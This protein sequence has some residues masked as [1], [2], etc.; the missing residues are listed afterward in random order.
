[1]K[2]IRA[3]FENFRLL[4]DPRIG[5]FD[6]Q[7]EKINGH[8]SGKMDTGKTTILNA[9]QWA[10]YGYEALPEKGKGFSA[11]TRLIGMPRLENQFR[12]L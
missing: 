12:Y 9:I 2:L 8:P 4:R 6:R 1:M 5:F 7:I 11:C 3:E 10:L